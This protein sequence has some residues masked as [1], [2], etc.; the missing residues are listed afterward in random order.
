MDGAAEKDEEEEE[1]ETA[2]TA[3]RDMYNAILADFAYDTTRDDKSARTLDRILDEAGVP[4]AYPALRKLIKGETVLVAGSGPSLDES[5]DTLARHADTAVLIA[6][7][8][9]AKPLVDRGIM[10]HVI[11]TD[12][13]GDIECH[14]EASRR[15]A[16][17]IAHA[18]GDN[19]HML[20]HVR[21][22]RTCMGTTQAGPVGRIRNLGGF[23]DGDRAVFAADHFGAN[24]IILFGMDLD[25][26]KVGRHSRTAAPD[27]A[28]KAKKLLKARE[29]LE[30]WLAG[31]PRQGRRLYT[32]S[33]CRIAGFEGIT[34]GD[35]DRLLAPGAGGHG[36]PARQEE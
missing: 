22:F 19:M 8:T 15:G 11:V 31:R 16:A 21:R 23:T 6:A 14:A 2:T 32:A 36:G 12:L 10:P 7:D 3:W 17:I 29:L 33:G 30:A 1:T 20:H 13:D 24:R 18:H 25:G 9:A 35:V 27:R 26:E 28:T 4:D 34:H 5:L